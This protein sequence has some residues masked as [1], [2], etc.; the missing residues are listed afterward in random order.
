MQCYVQ[1]NFFFCTI[2]KRWHIF[3]YGLFV[4]R[5]WHV[6]CYYIFM[7]TKIAIPHWQGRVSPVF[8]VA[9][10]VVLAEFVSGEIVRHGDL[11]LGAEDSQA[12]ADILLSAGVEVLICGAISCRYER[13]LTSAG[14]EVI[15]QICGEIDRV[16]HAY[17]EG[18]L[19]YYQMPGCR[20][21]CGRSRRGR[22]CKF[23]A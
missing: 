22:G 19:S 3:P 15:S 6:N 12:R 18:R 14:I 11:L 8:D 9:G 5:L 20:G 7:M 1:E 17:A 10:R 2:E 13:A 16:L 21:R 4:F 23:R